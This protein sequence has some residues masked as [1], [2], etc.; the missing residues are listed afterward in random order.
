MLLGVSSK[1]SWGSSWGV[2]FCSFCAGLSVILIG[3][4][5]FV[6]SAERIVKVPS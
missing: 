5:I 4:T 3:R 1:G 6:P 2:S